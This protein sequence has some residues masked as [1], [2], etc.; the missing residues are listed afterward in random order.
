VVTPSS[1]PSSAT[2]RPDADLSSKGFEEVLENF[3]DEPT[4]KK[5]ISDY[6]EEKGDDHE[7]EAMGTYLSYLLSFPFTLIYIYIYI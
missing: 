6:N 7:A 4:I 3:D 2:R 5:K 1:I